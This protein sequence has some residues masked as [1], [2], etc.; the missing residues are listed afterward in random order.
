[1]MC[2]RPVSMDHFFVPFD[3]V[4]KDFK[5]LGSAKPFSHVSRLRLSIFNGCQFQD[6][7]QGKNNKTT[8][9]EHALHC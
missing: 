2:H 4:L 1:M 7:R 5:I 9:T 8:P 3:L 6:K